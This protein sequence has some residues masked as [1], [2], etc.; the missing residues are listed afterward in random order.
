V[1][2]LLCSHCHGSGLHDEEV[3]L[4]G[5]VPLLDRPSGVDDDAW[6]ATEVT[7]R[8]ELPVRD[9]R[10]DKTVVCTVPTFRVPARLRVDR[11][12][13]PRIVAPAREGDT[14]SAMVHMLTPVKGAAVLAPKKRGRGWR[15]A[16]LSIA[17]VV[18]LAAAGGTRWKS[19]LPRLERAVSAHRLLPR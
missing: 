6:D 15:V 12:V 18:A 17:L 19:W 9:E 8:A 4:R 11:V 2:K 3:T 5:I 10:D 1:R 14:G 16:L 7:K 13:S